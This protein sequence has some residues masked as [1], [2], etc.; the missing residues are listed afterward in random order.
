VGT[1]LTYNRNAERPA[2]KMWIFDDDGQLVDFSG[3]S[4]VLKIGSPGSTAALTK[5]TNITGGVGAGTEPDGTANVTVNWTAGELDIE[6]GNY[7]W[8]LTCTT[9]SLDRVYEGTIRIL[10][11]IN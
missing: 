3:Y 6:P 10:E 11:D 1:K 8:Q 4:F 2:A 5:S 9:S 7:H